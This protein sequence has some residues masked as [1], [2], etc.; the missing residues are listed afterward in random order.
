M[1]QLPVTVG[2]EMTAAVDPQKRT[3]D[4]YARQR[5]V[6]AAA[7]AAK[8]QFPG[9]VGQFLAKE[10]LQWSEFGRFIGGHGDVEAVCY[11]LLTNQPPRTIGTLP[12]N[13]A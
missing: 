10:L 9:P 7:H 13:V 8:E 1:R 2:D 12:G 6:E 4:E 3:A 5:R 11:Q